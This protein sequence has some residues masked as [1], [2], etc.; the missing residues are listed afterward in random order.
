MLNINTGLLLTIGSIFP[1]KIGGSI[2]NSKTIIIEC[3]YLYTAHIN[4][5]HGGLQFLLMKLE[6]DNNTGNYMPYSFSISVWVIQRPLLT[7]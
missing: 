3:M 6:M 5:S 4:M 1:I 7:M 2:A